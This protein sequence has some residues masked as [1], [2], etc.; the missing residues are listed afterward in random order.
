MI[1]TS[2]QE[3]RG[4]LMNASL[5][6][7]SA[8]RISEDTYNDGLE[9]VEVNIN[10][11]QIESWHVIDEIQ[12][13]E[14][15]LFGYVLKNPISEQIVIS[16]RGTEM[17]TSVT[18]EVKSK[19]VGSPSQ[20]AMLASGEASIENGNLVYEKNTISKSDIAESNKDVTEDL[21]GIVLGNSNYT[22]K[23][24]G[25]TAY[26]GTPSQDASLAS[27][28]AELDAKAG[29]IS[30]IHKNQFT[31]AEEK[32]DHYVDKYGAKNITFVGH[33]LGGGLAQYFAVNHDSNAV[34]FAAADIYSLLTPDQQQ[35]AINGEY[36]DNVISYTYPD[37][38]VGTY[39]KESVGSVYYVGDPS[40]SSMP[41][42]ETHGIKNYRSDGM[43]NDEG[44][45]LPESL[46]DE[47][48]QSQLNLSPLA[49]KNSGV[50]D[51]HIQIQEALMEM[52]VQEMKQSEEQIEA[53]KQALLEFLDVYMNT[54]R[55]MKSKYINSVGS[56]QFDK[57]NAS[58]V[59]SYFHEFTKA[60]VDGVP[61]LFDIQM[62]DSLMA[63]LGD[64]HQDTA[65]IAYNM[66]RMSQDLMRAD[67]YLA[68]WLRYE[69]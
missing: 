25:T 28:R 31:E 36:K 41:W 8:M 5:I 38:M 34:T 64:T 21:E 69:S 37:D 33:S 2:F 45:F 59:E 66:E 50:S 58:D 15:G 35:R 57:L 18:T 67:Q 56:G 26:L 46:F 52:Y 40:D 6:D 23:R 16:F 14:T 17:P 43:Y 30:Y 24:Y 29:T 54:M 4:L 51:F 55:D 53:T 48:F 68:Q 20:D 49:L 44:Y 60:P 65:D 1:L 27:G 42:L 63:S 61:M 13:D 39:Y 47:S 12:N 9:V 10:D 32:V 11:N 3:L 19:Y 7:K 62:F 22:K